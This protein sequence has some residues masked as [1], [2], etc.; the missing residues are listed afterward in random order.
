M[1]ACF[2]SSENPG[3]CEDLHQVVCD[4]EWDMQ[5]LADELEEAGLA[6]AKAELIRRTVHQVSLDPRKR[7]MTA[8]DCRGE[9]LFEVALNAHQWAIVRRTLDRHP[10]TADGAA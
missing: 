10:A 6:V 7:R 3:S 2:H 4:P 8:R 9:W 1:V 5:A